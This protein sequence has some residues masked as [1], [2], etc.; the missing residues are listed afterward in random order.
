MTQAVSSVNE[1]V[2]PA[3]GAS[4]SVFDERQD[5]QTPTELRRETNGQSMKTVNGELYGTKNDQ[6]FSV[7]GKFNT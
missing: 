6:L 7:T 1:D 4:L 3:R 2:V 5:R